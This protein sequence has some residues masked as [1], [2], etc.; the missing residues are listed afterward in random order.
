MDDALRGLD[1]YRTTDRSIAVPTVTGCH[2]CNGNGSEE[3]GPCDR[4]GCQDEAEDDC[5]L[6]RIVAARAAAEDCYRARTRAFQLAGRY[7]L[8]GD[9][10]HTLRVR[11]AMGAAVS[12]QRQAED[13]TR[14]ARALGVA[15]ISFVEER[16]AAE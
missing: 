3:D 7:I 2:W 14:K 11:D 13:F 9:S 15:R 10:P 4:Q 12:W 1:T 16:S 6:A 5:R 8:E